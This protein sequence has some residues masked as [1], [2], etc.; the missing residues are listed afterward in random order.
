MNLSQFEHKQAYIKTIR[1]EYISR[2]VLR[3]IHTNKRHGDQIEICRKRGR[4]VERTL[5]QD[6]IV[7]IVE[8]KLK[9]KTK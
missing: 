6:Q 4:K 7:S 1:G 5:N 9:E 3:Y 8:L 2:Y